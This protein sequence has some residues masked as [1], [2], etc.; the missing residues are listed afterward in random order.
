[1]V[2][3]LNLKQRRFRELTGVRLLVVALEMS[4][5]QLTIAVALCRRL[6]SIKGS[7]GVIVAEVGAMEV[8]CAVARVR[9]LSRIIPWFG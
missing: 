7:M 6:S 3:F 9:Q 8:A 2:G 1:M 4:A 5:A